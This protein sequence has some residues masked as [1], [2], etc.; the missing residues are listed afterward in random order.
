LIGCGQFEPAALAVRL[1]QQMLGCPI[2]GAH[3]AAAKDH[4]GCSLQGH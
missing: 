2:V 1:A 3:L 4:L